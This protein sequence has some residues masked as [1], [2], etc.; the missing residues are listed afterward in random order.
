MHLRLGELLICIKVIFQGS[1]FGLKAP[2]LQVSST[3]LLRRVMSDSLTR[4]TSKISLVCCH[5]YTHMSLY[6]RRE[7]MHTSHMGLGG[8]ITNCRGHSMEVFEIKG[9]LSSIKF[10]ATPLHPVSS[11]ESE[12]LT[13]CIVVKF[14]C[15]FNFSSSSLP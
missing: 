3:G 5:T 10:P 1:F 2:N 15:S 14:L 9:G 7:W 12:N 6:M 8:R 4:V 11:S 13:H